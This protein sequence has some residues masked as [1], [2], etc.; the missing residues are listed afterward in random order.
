[1]ITL[2]EM[3][4]GFVTIQMSKDDLSLLNNIVYEGSKY[5]QRKTEKLDLMQLTLHNLYEM[6]HHGFITDFG[7]VKNAEFAIKYNEYDYN[8]ANTEE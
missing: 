3:D 2:K 7:R 4:E 5:I 8:A 1:M 6:V